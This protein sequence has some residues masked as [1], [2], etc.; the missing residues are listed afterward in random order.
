[1]SAVHFCKQQ[2]G[3]EGRKAKQ[4]VKKHVQATEDEVKTSKDA[5]SLSTNT[6]EDRRTDYTVEDSELMRMKTSGQKRQQTKQM[7]RNTAE[8]NDPKSAKVSS[9]ITR[10]FRSNNLEN[11]EAII[12][13]KFSWVVAVVLLAVSLDFLYPLS[14]QLLPPT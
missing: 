7:S 2:E 3:G 9:S 5:L 6:S 11:L 8:G 4:Q 1:M 14:T 12:A 10:K 13:S